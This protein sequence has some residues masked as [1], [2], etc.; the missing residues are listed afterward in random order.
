MTESMSH[1]STTTSS[2]RYSSLVGFTNINSR[3]TEILGGTSLDV[4]PR[5]LH[6]V[7]IDQKATDDDYAP[8]NM[9]SQYINI[10]ST[11]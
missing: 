3:L 4:R 11:T 1:C 8:K 2:F 9:H 7:V 10:D 6:L 5:Q